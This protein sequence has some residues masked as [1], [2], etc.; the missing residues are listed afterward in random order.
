MKYIK[1][2]RILIESAPVD[3]YQIIEDFLVE[4]RFSIL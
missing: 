4:L 2:I 3:L 1:L